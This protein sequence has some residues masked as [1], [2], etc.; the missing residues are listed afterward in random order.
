MAVTGLVLPAELESPAQVAFE[1]YGGMGK[2]FVPKTTRRAALADRSL[3]W[4]SQWGVGTNMAFRRALFAEIGGFDP[5]LDV[6]T[7][8]GGG[9]S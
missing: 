4:A 8:A 7:P 2:G 6:G 9:G 5:A 3:L 1:R